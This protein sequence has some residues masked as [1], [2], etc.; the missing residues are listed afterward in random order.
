TE[1]KLLF[2]SFVAE[3]F[4]EKPVTVD[5]DRLQGL[6]PVSAPSEK[7]NGV[8]SIKVFHREEPV[9]QR[10][11][12]SHRE[13]Y[14]LTNIYIYPV[15]SCGAYEVHNWPVG[16]QGLLYDRGWMVV[17]G[18]G[19]CL[20][21]KREPRLCL[22]RP[23]VHLPS[24]KFPLR[25]PECNP[26]CSRVET[27]DCGGEAASWL[28]DFLGQPCRLIRQSPDFTRE[29]KKRPCDGMKGLFNGF[30]PDSYWRGGCEDE[31]LLDS[32]NVIRRF[33]ANLVITGGEPFEEDNWSHLII[34]STRFVV[35]QCG[36]CQ[37]VGIDQD[38]GAKS[39]EPLMS[40]S[41]LRGG[42]VTFGVYLSHETPDGSATAN[43][44]SVGSVIQPEP[45]RH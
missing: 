19:V 23:R 32:Q 10:E 27:V 4:V 6:L 25:P 17:N 39:K 34:G 28:S 30:T 7:S 8:S 5:P 18:N 31:E 33:R 3:C 21:Q 9:E 26:L 12:D 2:L 11:S 35:S 44:L 42:K 41:A 45:H 36:R 14:T 13:A 24:N 40:L 43:V 15:K 22:I 37:M 16:P 29:M 38:T 20:N 1:R